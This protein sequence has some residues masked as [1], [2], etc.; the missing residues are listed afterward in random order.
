MVIMRFTI[1]W[2]LLCFVSA[3]S[4]GGLIGDK[5]QTVPPVDVSTFP[6]MRVVAYDI[7]VP[8]S[9][10][11]S[12]DNAYKPIADIVWRGD[13]YGSRYPQVKAIFDAGVKKG[14]STVSGTVPVRLEIVVRRFHSQSERVRY[15][16]GGKYEIEYDL[17]I[18]AS[19]V[20]QVLVPTYT[21]Y[22]E[23]DAPGGIAALAAE[24]SGRTEKIDNINLIAQS[25]YTQL[26]GKFPAVAS[27]ALTKDSPSVAQ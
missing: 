11:V 13:P 9:L 19:G 12:E 18:S 21:V 26:T 1:A 4:V 23:A 3:C 20:G 5:K 17:T 24:Q 27:A 15:S 25:I 8:T 6:P 2:F 14:I 22:I 10:S 16:Y 7:T